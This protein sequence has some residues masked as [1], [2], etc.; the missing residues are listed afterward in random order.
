[1]NPVRKKRLILVVILLG[2]FAVA[3]TLA[4]VVFQ[5]NINL[6]Y[7]P[8]EIEEGEAPVDRRIRAGGL[9]EDDSVIRDPESLLVR[10]SITDMK[11]SVP[12]EYTGILP[13]LFR[14]GQG[15]VAMGTM[16]DDGVFTADQVLA[17][18]D[19]EYMPPEVAEALE[20]AGKL[21][22][23]DESHYASDEGGEGYGYDDE[24]ADDD[25]DD[26]SSY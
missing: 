5:Q 11:G 24:G 3:V 6:F 8:A 22:T 25:G 19:E 21:K 10:F 15:V 12:V 13:D 17:K 9:V 7:S 14:E 20:R 23:G 2:G 1:M 26:E 16:D 4:L 18:H